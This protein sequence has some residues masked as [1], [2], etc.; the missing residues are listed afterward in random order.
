MR[1]D[2]VNTQRRDAIKKLLDAKGE[3]VLTE[4][5]ALFPDCSSMTLRRDLKYLE[6]NG[7]VKRTRGGAVALSR[8]SIAAEDVYSRRAVENTEAKTII[9]K[10]AAA[11]LES[12]RALYIDTGTTM[13]QFAK[14]IPDDYI[15]ILTSGPN[16]ALELIKKSRP[17]VTLI[18]GQLSRNTLSVSG[19]GTNRF[20]AGVNIDIAFMSSSGLSLQHGFTSGTYSEC[21]LKREVLKMA[22][23]VIMLM[24]SSKVGKNLPYT[25]GA[26][27]DIDVLVSDDRLPAEIVSAAKQGGVTVI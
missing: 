6:D 4:L 24:D 26:L 13:M 10:K 3:I 14:E 9:A 25:F 15:S 17:N 12:G 7:L 23:R 1:G 5:E 8:L 18:G 20:L 27:S 22:S 11:L 21:E 2:G 16:I 19:A